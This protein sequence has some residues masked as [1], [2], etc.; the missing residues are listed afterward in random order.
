MLSFYGCFPREEDYWELISNLAYFYHWQ[1]NFMDDMTDW[2]ARK[3]F[4]QA[5]RINKEQERASK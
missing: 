5:H 1:P 3:W 2:E 4:E